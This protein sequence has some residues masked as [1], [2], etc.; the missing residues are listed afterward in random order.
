[1][2]K[3]GP[4]PDNKRPTHMDEQEEAHRLRLGLRLLERV[5][6]ELVHSRR[7]G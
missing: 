5:R 6:L 7:V 4:F 1:M 2:G 3:G